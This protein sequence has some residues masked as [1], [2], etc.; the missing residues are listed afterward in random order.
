MYVFSFAMYMVR[1]LQMLHKREP[2]SLVVSPVSLKLVLAMVYE[3]ADNHTAEELR[4]ALNLPENR[5][6]SRH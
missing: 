3:G 5:V 1:L 2:G 6:D 4:N